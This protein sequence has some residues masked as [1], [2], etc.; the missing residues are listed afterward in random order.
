MQSVPISEPETKFSRP[1]IEPQAIYSKDEAANLTGTSY[2]TIH[3]AIE[4]GKLRVARLN[5]RVAIRG[6]ALLRWIESCEA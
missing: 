2:S 5:R 1:S 3:R 4:A 6:E